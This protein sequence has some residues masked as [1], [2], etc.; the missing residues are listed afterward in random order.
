MFSLQWLNL[1][2]TG[3]PVAEIQ[4]TAIP[5][6][7]HRQLKLLRYP[8]L[9][10]EVP[11]ADCRGDPNKGRVGGIKICEKSFGLLAMYY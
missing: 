11:P 1:A 4:N 5:S 3:P 6:Q 2:V 9:W 10:P 7:G 8:T